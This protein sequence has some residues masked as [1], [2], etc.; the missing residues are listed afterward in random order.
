MKQNALIAAPQ[1]DDV[2]S[3]YDLWKE[4]HFGTPG[5]FYDFMTTPNAARAEFLQRC[6]MRIPDFGGGVV[7]PIYTV[8]SI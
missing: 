5:D 3:A 4:D 2:M 6:K 1:L 8:E 7:T